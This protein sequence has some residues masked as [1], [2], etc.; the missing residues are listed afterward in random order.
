VDGEGVSH[1]VQARLM[2]GTGGFAYHLGTDPQAAEG[3]LGVLP[4]HRTAPA[5]DKE[6]RGGPGM[7][8]VAPCGVRGQNLQ[9]VIA[10]RHQPALVELALADAEDPGIDVDIGHSECKR[11]AYAQTCAIKQEQDRPIGVGTNAATWM[12]VRCDRIEQAPQFLARVNIGNKGFLWLGNG[13][14]KRRMVDIA[15][16]DSEPV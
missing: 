9:Q 10:D 12:V 16:G 8:L 11:L 14:R 7:P 13:P 2:S 3:P 6:W 1:V 5:G 4:G 15:P